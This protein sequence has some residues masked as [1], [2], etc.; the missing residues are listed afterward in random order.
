MQNI[1]WAV[2]RYFEFIFTNQQILMLLLL[3]LEES[4]ED[5]WP[6]DVGE[7]RNTWVLSPVITHPST[8]D[9]PPPSSSSQSS[10]KVRVTRFLPAAGPEQRV[11]A[12]KRRIIPNI[13][14]T[15]CQVWDDQIESPPTLLV[16][17]RY[18]DQRW[19][20]K[21]KMVSWRFLS[22]YFFVEI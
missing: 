15:Q 21:M 16:T 3:L 7:D 11:W 4:S 6:V 2:R 18:K 22:L 1:S 10:P 12:G 14:C 13:I 8:H 5:D 20:N 17:W 19:V 9:C